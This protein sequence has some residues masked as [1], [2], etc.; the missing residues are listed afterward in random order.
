MNAKTV[1]GKERQNKKCPSNKERLLRE[2]EDQTTLSRKQKERCLAK[3]NMDGRS[4]KRKIR[5]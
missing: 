5:K 1:L 3:F 4:G 2:E